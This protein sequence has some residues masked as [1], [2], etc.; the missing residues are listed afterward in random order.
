M[1]TKKPK[2]I[3][4][5]ATFDGNKSHLFALDE[6]GGVWRFANPAGKPVQWVKLTS[7]REEES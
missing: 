2:F 3:Q 4:I 6:D 1:K 5:T 7:H